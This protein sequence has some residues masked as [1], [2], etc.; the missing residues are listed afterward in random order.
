MT[1]LKQSLEALVAEMREYGILYPEA[2]REFKR[3]FIA[4]TVVANKG[5]QSRAAREMLLHRNTL[6]RTIN[7]LK[8]RERI[9]KA[10]PKPPRRN[11]P[12]SAFDAGVRAKGEAA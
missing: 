11:R 10:R 5:N 7:E 8:I 6:S 9:R 4:Q 1:D 3:C 12:F 2:L